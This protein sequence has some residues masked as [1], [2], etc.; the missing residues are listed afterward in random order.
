MRLVALKCYL[1]IPTFLAWDSTLAKPYLLWN[2]SIGVIWIG[3]KIELFQ[4]LLSNIWD[5]ISLTTCWLTPRQSFLLL[6]AGTIVLLIF[7]VL[8]AI[9]CSLG[10]GRSVSESLPVSTLTWETGLSSFV[11]LEVSLPS[12]LCSSVEPDSNKEPVAAVLC[13]RV[14]IWCPGLHAC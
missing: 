6:R 14:Y 12:L 13:W 9:F 7:F 3:I 1:S 2:L 4:K 11:C 8:T 5:P 10:S